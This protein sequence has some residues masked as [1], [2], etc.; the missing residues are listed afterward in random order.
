MEQLQQAEAELARVQA[1]I[2]AL[3]ARARQGGTEF[4]SAEGRSIDVCN[5]RCQ[6]KV[7]LVFS[8]GRSRRWAN[9]QMMSEEFRCRVKGMHIQEVPITPR[10]PWQN[11]YS[12]RVLGEKHLPRILQC[13][14]A[15]YG[16]TRTHLSLAK[17]APSSRPYSHPR[18]ETSSNCPR[19]VACIIATNGVQPNAPTPTRLPCPDLPRLAL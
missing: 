14:F 4:A 12:E 5:R 9:H 18:W 11:P 16:Q 3:W 15:Y 1:E 13:Y 8:N 10:S 6:S 7:V 17:D 2:A 19:L